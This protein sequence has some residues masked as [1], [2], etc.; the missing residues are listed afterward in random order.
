MKTNWQ[1]LQPD[2]VA[3]R[4]SEMLSTVSVHL[5]GRLNGFPIQTI[6]CQVAL[7][8]LYHAGVVILVHMY[9]GFFC[10]NLKFWFENLTFFMKKFTWQEKGEILLTEKMNLCCLDLWEP[11]CCKTTSPYIHVCMRVTDDISE[12][13]LWAG[14]GPTSCCCLPS[15]LPVHP[16]TCHGRRKINTCLQLRQA[17]HW[18]FLPPW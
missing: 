10:Q 5:R 13:S 3:R 4:L 16:L 8:T 6:F 12:W 7:D 15:F 2:V 11:R 1:L 18:T 9:M 14:E 17:R